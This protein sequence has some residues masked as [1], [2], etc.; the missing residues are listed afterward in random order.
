[1]LKPSE[2]LKN[3]LGL[4]N[5]PGNIITAVILFC[6]AVAT[7]MPAVPFDHGLH[8]RALNC[9]DCHHTSVKQSCIT[10]H[11]PSGDHNRYGCHQ[12]N[13]WAGCPGPAAKSARPKCAA[14]RQACAFS[15]PAA[16]GRCGEG[17]A[18]VCRRFGSSACGFGHSVAAAGQKS[19]CKARPGSQRCCGQGLATCGNAASCPKRSTRR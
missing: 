11:T 10:C 19:G 14:E 4:L 7:V 2:L 15:N 17:C 1:M 3:T 5:T 6:G 18:A 9:V 12:W 16:S 8:E 13:R